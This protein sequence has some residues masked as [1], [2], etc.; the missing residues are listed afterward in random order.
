MFQTAI[1]IHDDI[2]DNAK[3]RREKETIPRRICR[4][5]LDLSN[6][7]T[8][9]EDVL[10]LANSLGICAGDY[11]FFEANKL[12]VKNYANNPHLADILI[13]Y[14]DIVTKTIEGEIIDVALPFYGKYDIVKPEEADV[15]NIYHLK[16]SFYTIIGPFTLGYL[17]GGKKI[18]EKLQNVLDKIGISFQIKDDILGIFGDKKK[19]GKS[20]TSDISEFKQTILYTYIINTPYKDEFLKIY[21]NKIINDKDLN[22]IRNLLK[23]SGSYDYALSYLEELYSNTLL[24]ID[25]LDLEDDGKDLLKGLLIYLHNRKK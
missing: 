16:T 6:D 15:L 25:D 17:L 4:K 12:I 5:Y 3:I 21:G 9:H 11:G 19:T 20:N 23:I 7:A 24:E 22:K 18:D 14:N 8:Y 2:I 10:K 13:E 1:L